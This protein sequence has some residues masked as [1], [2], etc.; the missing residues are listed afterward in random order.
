MAPAASSVAHDA[1]PQDEQRRTAAAASSAT[2]QAS[3]SAPASGIAEPRI[4]PTAAG[5]RAGEERA[6][7]RVGEQP[8]E[9]PGAEQDERERRGE[10]DQRREQPAA[11]AVRRVPDGGD[12]RHHRPR[13]GLTEG[14]RVEELAAGH[15]VVVLHGVALHERDDHEAA[16]ERERA[17]LQ[18]R[19]RQR[20]QPAGARGDRSGGR[21]AVEVQAACDDPAAHQLQRAAAEQDEHEPG[22][23]ERRGHAA[24]QAVGDDPAAVGPARAAPP[25]RRQQAPP[26]E[27]RHRGDRRARAQSDAA[28]PVRRRGRQER[29]RQR[30]DERDGGGD[31]AEAADHGARGAAQPPGAVDRHLRGARSGQEAGRGDGALEVLVAQ[32]ASALDAQ[33]AQHRDVRRRSPEAGAADA[34]PLA[35]DLAERGRGHGGGIIAASRPRRPAA[36]NWACP[37][38]RT[39]RRAAEEIRRAATSVADEPFL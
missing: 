22:P 7:A 19:P 16:A 13:R 27:H 25:H 38:C 14:D 20:A 6:R 31:E 5:R 35:R 3:S 10:G 32:P 2:C 39:A 8:V 30:E 36:S 34:T 23:G 18:R 24:G 37:H 17:D 29:D 11:D 26:G 21:P 28:Q 9:A 15:P 1:A 12:R 4:A 33:L